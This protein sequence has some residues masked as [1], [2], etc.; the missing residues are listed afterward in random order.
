MAELMGKTN[1]ELVTGI[2][3]FSKYG[4]LSQ[5]MIMQAL[6]QFVDN[7]VECKDR[8]LFE[9]EQLK[10]EKPNAVSII[11]IKVWIDVAE[12]IQEKLKNK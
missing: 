7:V 4:A 1:I 10:R 3:N 11:N 2:M 12:E 8:L 6:H 5:A 9:E